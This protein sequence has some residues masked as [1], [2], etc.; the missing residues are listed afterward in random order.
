MPITNPMLKLACD[1]FEAALTE[2]VKV[3]SVKIAGDADDDPIDGP[4]PDVA[5]SSPP[6]RGL[7]D[8]SNIKIDQT[9]VPLPATG[10]KD[11]NAGRNPDGSI[12]S[13]TSPTPVTPP[14]PIKPAA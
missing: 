11:P 4:I 7:G 12:K 3:A 10:K 8:V 6:Q 5:P 2:A 9:G 13:V 1:T 14:A